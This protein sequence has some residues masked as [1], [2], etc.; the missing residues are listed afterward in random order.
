[1]TPQEIN[2]VHLIKRSFEVGLPR[3]K[4]HV[5]SDSNMMT[6]DGRITMFKKKKENQNYSETVRQKEMSNWRNR[7]VLIAKAKA[8]QYSHGAW[9]PN[10]YV[11]GEFTKS[12]ADSISYKMR[13]LGKINDQPLQEN[14]FNVGIPQRMVD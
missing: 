12:S 14:A 6:R 8:T 13:T 4:K 2:K 11:K 9:V 1:M 5:Q 7:R 10:M 3:P